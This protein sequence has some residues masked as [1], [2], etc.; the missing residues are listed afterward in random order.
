MK[1][2]NC[3][4]MKNIDRTAIDEIG[5]P[6]IVLMENAALK[7]VEEIKGTLGE[8][9]YKSIVI[10]CGK[11]NNGGDGFAIARHLRNMGANVLVI[12]LADENEIKGDALINFKIIRQLSIKIAQVY[13]R[14]ALEEIAASLYMCDLVV[15]AIFGTGIKGKIT[16]IADDIIQL[17]NFSGRYVISVD[18]PSGINGDD[19][20]ICGICVN[21]DKTVTFV[22]PKI[23]L[24]NFP[25]ADYVG[26]LVIADISIPHSI[27]QAQN[28]N[29]NTIGRE[30]IKALLP[31]RKND[32]NKGDYG[33]IVVV[34]GST[35]MTGAAALAATAA[36]RSG[37]GLVTVGIPKSLNMLMEVKLTE[38]MSLPLE[39]DGKGVL[40]QSCTSQILEK[41]CKTDVLVF[42]PGLT[43]EPSVSDILADILKKADIP[44]I[45]DADG[46]NALAK[47]INILKECNCPVVITPHP[48][49]M[50]RLTGLD[51]RHI[52]SDR[53]EVAQK[54]AQEW[55]VTVVLKGARTIIACPTGE[56]FINTTGNP[57]MATGGTG[58][59]LSGLIA[60]LIGQGL[61]IN[62]AAMMGV[63]I[64]GFAADLEV[65][66]KG[67]HGLIAT[68]IVEALPM[69]FYELSN[70]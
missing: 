28:I 65:G 15:D 56:T 69:A 25:A 62:R 29:I 49:E 52:Q 55:Q 21:A 1:V 12:L 41:M 14:T 66:Q 9:G 18:I 31:L 16:G 8:I 11:G 26:E 47:N 20:R 64:H 40:S 45:I 44:I 51:I 24:L 37:S 59:V 23:G 70:A 2:A 13:N 60:S 34:A 19:G 50:S 46:I 67:Q 3:S 58:D 48:G 63:Y 54:F 22:L 33:K 35:G 36:L 32:S 38:A 27:I 53:I 43:N 4:Q 30:D 7:V 42:G 39:D 10:F 68:D 57:G 6:G 61:D 17:I 5:I